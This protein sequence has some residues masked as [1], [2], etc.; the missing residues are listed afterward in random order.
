MIVGDVVNHETQWVQS[1]EDGHVP[2][3]SSLLR[4]MV[5]AIRM[6]D[7][8]MCSFLPEQGV[9]PSSVLGYWDSEMNA[10]GTLPWRNSEGW[11]WACQAVRMPSAQKV[12]VKVAGVSDSL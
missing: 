10:P 2:L 6:R 7:F 9:E 5:E 11:H 8:P 12:K 4:V 1:R 3:W